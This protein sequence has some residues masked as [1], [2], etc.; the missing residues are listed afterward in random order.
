MA[1]CPT[2]SLF[3]EAVHTGS[4]AHTAE[5]LAKDIS[6][7]I[8]GIGGNV[9]GCVTDNTAANKKAWK[10]LEEK[11]PNLFFHGCVS[12]RLNLLVKDIFGAKKKQCDDGGPAQYPE[13]YPFEDLLL[14]A[15]DCK[16]VVTFFYNHHAPM[17]DLKKAL[18]SAKL[19]GLVRPA[20]TRWGTIQG[21]FESLGGAD[22]VLNGLVSQRDFTTTGNTSQKET[23][24][25]IK[26]TIT[27]PDFVTKLDECIKILQPI[28]TLIKMFQ[29]DAIP[30]SDVYKAFLDLESKMSGLVGV[31]A[32][33]KAHLVKLVQKRFDFM[34]GDAHG[35]AYLL[36]PR[37]LGDNMT[38]KLRKEIEDFI[39]QFPTPDGTTCDERKEKLAQEYTAFCID[40]LEER[41]KNGF[42]FK[43]I[44]ESQSVLHWWMADGTDW[45]LLQNLAVRV[46]TMASLSAASERNFST[47]GFI[48]S[49]L[50]NRLSP[51]KV[52]KLVY[53]KTNAI[54]MA[55]SPGMECYEWES[56][57]SE[58]VME[59]D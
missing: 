33:K 40:A 12:H 41:E 35:M 32:E 27:D 55:D 28:D 1:V 10:E 59:V 54:L 36:D 19:G 49:K 22:N 6:R 48:H 51:E 24:A 5:W 25:A 53:I 44:G 52:K 38:R 14:F 30:C 58:G 9:V 56:D 11:Y 43:M 17:A 20:P 7:V 47:F 50:R 4:Q 46:F 57:E 15:A 45:P 34:Y 18:K 13:G 26:H 21:C 37:Y 42:C 8:D 16:D 31:N 29:S 2:K 3:L 39:F 23:R